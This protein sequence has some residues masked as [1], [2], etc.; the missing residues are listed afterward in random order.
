MFCLPLSASLHDG[1]KLMRKWEDEA[2][3]SVS[4]VAQIVRDAFS[5]AAILGNSIFLLDAYYFSATLLKEQIKQES[6]LCRKLSIVTRAK[7]ST[8]AYTLPV[9]REGRGRPR[10]KGE[11]IKLSSVFDSEE[12]KFISCFRSPDRAISC[13]WT[14]AQ[15]IENC[16]L[17]VSG[18]GVYT[19]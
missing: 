7:I 10:K 12:K 18:K 19:F 9:A 14:M 2:Y 3:E 11:A 1:D 6:Q 15:N 17:E 4:H 8:I 5:I 16:F 13:S